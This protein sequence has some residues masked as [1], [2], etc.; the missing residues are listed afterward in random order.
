MRNILVNWKINEFE[1]QLINRDITGYCVDFIKS[2]YIQMQIYSKVIVEKTKIKEY[3]NICTYG[4][5]IEVISKDDDLCIEYICGIND[6]ERAYVITSII[7]VALDFYLNNK[8]MTSDD[9]S[10]YA[11]IM[12]GNIKAH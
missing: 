8:Y 12:R 5:V 10:K 4:P 11:Y 6:I 3:G 7:E 2:I 1:D 9:M